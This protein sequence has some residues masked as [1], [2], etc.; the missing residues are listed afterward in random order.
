MTA[1][2]DRLITL[3]VSAATAVLTVAAVAFAASGDGMPRPSDTDLPHV[4]AVAH[5]DASAVS[6]A[7][8]DSAPPTLASKT[9]VSRAT[10]KKSSGDSKKN[11]ASASSGRSRTAS[12][13]R[14]PSKP[15]HRSSHTTSKTDHQPSGT[16][17]TPKT[18]PDSG[19]Q[20]NDHEVVT[21]H[22]HESDHSADTNNTSGGSSHGSD[23][24]SKD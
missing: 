11:P 19:G 3:G 15:S 13:R 14:T 7:E 20:S 4:Q 1:T 23:S 8:V 18:T 24:K 9:R 22:V 5:P 12:R 17:D 16:A 2:R 10:T 21:P 6:P